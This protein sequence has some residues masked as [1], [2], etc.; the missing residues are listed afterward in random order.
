MSLTRGRFVPRFAVA[1]LV[2]AALALSA[3]G[4]KSGLDAPPTA[5]VAGNPNADAQAGQTPQSTQNGW[6]V[7]QAVAPKGS[8]KPIPLDVLLN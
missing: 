8:D 7:D 6:G 5:S 3:C 1:G 2:V 4:R